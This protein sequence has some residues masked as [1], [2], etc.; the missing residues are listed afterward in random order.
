M[1]TRSD[2]ARPPVIRRQR[3]GTSFL[4]LTQTGKFKNLCKKY[5]VSF[6]RELSVPS[7]RLFIGV[8]EKSK[9]VLM[10]FPSK[11]FSGDR[12]QDVLVDIR[13]VLNVEL[14]IGN[15]TVYQGGPIASLAG[16]A[17]GGIVSGGF[18]AI[19]GSI[20]AGKIGSGKISDVTLNLRVNDIN[21]PLVQ[22]EFVPKRMKSSKAGPL[23][24]AAENWTNLI[25]VMR[26]RIEK[27]DGR[28]M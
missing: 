14:S 12:M 15:N 1:R 7:S 16:A 13:E 19:V 9:V 4:Y 26:S 22:V 8:S 6:N 2:Q 28:G 10:S 20:A 18:G 21:T 24:K 25:E 11:G 23:L 3:L 27:D 17:V 5:K